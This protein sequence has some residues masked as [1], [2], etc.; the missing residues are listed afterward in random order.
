MT[1]NLTTLLQEISSN[2][3]FANGQVGGTFKVNGLPITLGLPISAGTEA[4]IQQG[5]QFA[6][7]LATLLAPNHAID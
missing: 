7:L 5:L 3:T 2:V 4:H 1:V 6:T